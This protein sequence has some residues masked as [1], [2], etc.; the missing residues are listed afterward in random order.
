VI[1]G[2]EKITLADWSQGRHTSDNQATVPNNALLVARNIIRQSGALKPTPGYTLVQDTTLK[3]IERLYSFERQT[4]QQ[5]FLMVTG[6]QQIARCKI[7]GSAPPAIMSNA[8]ADGDFDFVENAFALFAN[9]GARAWKLINIEGVET[10]VPWGLQPAVGPPAIA[11]GNGGLNLTYGTRYVYS[12]VFRWTDS[13]GTERYHISVP[14]DF[15]AHSGP[16]GLTVTDGAMNAT[17]ALLDSGTAGFTAGDV[18]TQIVVEGAGPSGG[19]LAATIAAYISADSVTLSVPAVTTVVGATV[20]YRLKAVTLSD[21]TA[22]NPQTTHFWIFRVQDSPIGASGTYF[23]V[24]EIPVAQSTYVDDAADVDLDTTREAPFLNYPPPLGNIMLE[25]GGRAVILNGDTVYLSALSEISLGVAYECFPAELEFIVPGGIKNLTAGIIF[26]QQ[27]LLSTQDYWFQISGQD[28]T[29]FQMLD[30]VIKPGSIGRKTVLV[31]HGRLIWLGTD[32]KLWTWNGVIG[33]DPVPMSVS[34]HGNS[35]DQLNM[36][37]LSTTY[38]AE[39]ELQWYSN[40]TF[41]W[42]VLVAASVDTTEGEK[43]WIQIWDLSPV[44]GVLT[45]QGPIPQPAESDFFPYD[46]FATSLSAESAGLPYIFFGGKDNGLVFRWPDGLLFNGLI[47]KD[48][49][50]GT[51]WIQL[52]DAKARSLFAKILTNMEDAK[53][54]FHFAAIASK[55]VDPSIQPVDVDLEADV[56]GAL[57]DD[58]VAR[59]NLMTQ[60]GTSFGNWLK[61]FVAFPADVATEDTLPD[62]SL[63]AIEIY[64]KPLPG[65]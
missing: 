23:F 50:V 5:Q 39:C 65:V 33:T 16:L 38:L 24:A 54:N 32:K 4:D 55:G 48:A 19:P 1:E 57:I 15:S 61:V 27:A 25:Y 42:I 20:N 14:S 6:G 17:S 13:L 46:L 60:P 56:D 18:G 44:T 12:E 40:G 3:L 7:D 11:L 8:E 29:T 21:I 63:S 31:V 37:D 52:A 30:Q 53:S 58:T 43:D 41:D 59:A 2:Q 62:L 9:N 45:I 35:L 49:L 22:V 34:L 47:V 51:P 26:Q 64:H 36:S 28:I 10:I